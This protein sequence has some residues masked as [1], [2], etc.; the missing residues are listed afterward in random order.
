EQ[1]RRTVAVATVLMDRIIALWGLFWFVLFLGAGFWL[2]GQLEGQGGEQSKL[3]I[4]IT[5]ALLAVSVVIWLAMGFLS[6]E[7]AELFALRLN[8][9]PKVGGSAAE[10]WRAVWAYRCRQLSVLLAIGFSWVGFGIFILAYY[11]CAST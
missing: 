11:F 2:T 4:E 7:Q 6:N 3:V 8:R 5:A 10:F 9:L 1:S